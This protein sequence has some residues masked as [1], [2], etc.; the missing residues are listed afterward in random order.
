MTSDTIQHGTATNE[1]REALLTCLQEAFED[2]FSYFLD[3]GTSLFATLDAVSA[4]EASRAAAP[5]VGTIAAQVNHIRFYLDEILRFV[6][7]GP[8]ATRP[9]WEGSWQVDAV[10]DEVW[11]TL[12]NQLRT[13]HAN[14]RDLIRNNQDWP[15]PMLTGAIAM[16]A[17][18]AYHLGE[19]RQAL[20]VIRFQS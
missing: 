13:S 6:S 9:D 1:I 14:I 5:T 15:A 2:G 3:R 19:I 17:H 4:A 10:T 8:P 12:R 20:A 18:C 11:D 16:I 7:E